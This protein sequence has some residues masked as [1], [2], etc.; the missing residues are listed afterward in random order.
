MGAMG[1]MMLAQ[2]FPDMYRGVAVFSGCYSTMDPLGRTAVQATISSRSGDP[3]NIWGVPGGPEWEAHDSLI[4]AEKLRGMEIY[5]STANGRPGS[6]ETLQTP[7]LLERLVIGGGIEVAAHAC[8][9]IFDARLQE[10]KIPAQVDYEPNGTHAWAYW[11]ERLP[12]AWPTLSRAL[13]V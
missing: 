8:T 1:A 11:R 9:K 13:G 2:R 4:N 3:A 6:D 10:L 12:K 5:V 7:E